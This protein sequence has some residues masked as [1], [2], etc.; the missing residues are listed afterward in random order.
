MSI[1]TTYHKPDGLKQCRFIIF[2]KFW[3]LEVSNQFYWAK[4]LVLTWL[5]LSR[6]SKELSI[7]L[8]FLT[9]EGYLNSLAHS[10]SL[11]HL[12]LIS[13]L[14]ICFLSD[15]LPSSYQTPVITAHLDDQMVS[16]SQGP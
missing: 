11:H 15:L 3:R 2:K 14:N 1:I 4:V 5:I 13:K 10:S 16:S 9:S 6:G 12:S 8:P 7:R